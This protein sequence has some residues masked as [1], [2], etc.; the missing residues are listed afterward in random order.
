MRIEDIID[1]LEKQYPDTVSSIQ[2]FEELLVA[3]AQQE[4]INHIKLMV[5]EP[6]RRK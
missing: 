3:K 5:Q 2:T 4:M 1:E 6:K